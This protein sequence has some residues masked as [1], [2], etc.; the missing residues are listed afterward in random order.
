MMA[1][2]VFL[3]SRAPPCSLETMIAATAS[4]QVEEI[5]SSVKL[6]DLLELPSQLVEKVE[7]GICLLPP[8]PPHFL[9]HPTYWSVRCQQNIQGEIS[10]RGK[11][12]GGIKFRASNLGISHTETRLKSMG[13]IREANTERR[14][15][16]STSQIIILIK[17]LTSNYD[18]VIK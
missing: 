14:E 2:V 13:K 1:S 9:A 7:L 8:S 11:W 4:C 18:L 16:R 12:K 6:N 3:N 5:L 17:Y 10:R 15:K